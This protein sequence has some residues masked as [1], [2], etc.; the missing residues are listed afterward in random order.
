M[1]MSNVPPMLIADHSTA[2]ET[3]LSV[4]ATAPKECVYC[5]INEADR[6]IQIYSTSNFVSHLNYLIQNLGSLEHQ[7]LRRDLNKVKVTIL[8]TKFDTKRHRDN[9]YRTLV[10][11]YRSEGWTFYRD[12]NI[13]LYTLKENYRMRDGVLYYVLELENPKRGRKKDRNILV[14]VFNSHREA[15]AWKAKHYPLTGMITEVVVADNDETKSW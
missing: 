4:L 6:R 2:L 9:K 11:R 7:Q 8:E 10:Q 14:G 13:T 15:M 12:T 1:S 3:V 5:L